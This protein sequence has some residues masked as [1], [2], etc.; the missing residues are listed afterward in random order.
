ML[1]INTVTL[2]TCSR[3]TDKCEVHEC[4]KNTYEC[5]VVTSDSRNSQKSHEGGN[6]GVDEVGGEEGDAAFS[7]GIILTTLRWKRRRLKV[8]R[9]QVGLN[10]L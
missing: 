2:D 9:A 1:W 5:N 10:C 7:D 8:L 6:W 4:E 3:Q